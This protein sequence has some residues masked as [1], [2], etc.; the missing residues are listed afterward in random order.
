MLAPNFPACLLALLHRVLKVSCSNLCP[1]TDLRNLV[2]F[3]FYFFFK[4]SLDECWEMPRAINLHDA[5]AA[6]GAQIVDFQ[7]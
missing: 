7:L 3:F 2:F 4:F 1:E 6:G 5:F